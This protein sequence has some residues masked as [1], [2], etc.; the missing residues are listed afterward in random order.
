LQDGAIGEI[1]AT[2]VYWNGTTPWVRT[3]QELEAQAG[4][5]LSEM[6]YQLRNWYYFTWICGDHIVEQHIHNLDVGNWL[7]GAYDLHGERHPILVTGSARLAAYSR[8]GDSLQGRY[9]LH[10]LHPLTLSEL[11]GIG[12]PEDPEEIPRLSA[13]APAGAEEALEGLDRLGGFP[14]P[15]LSGS[16]RTAARWRLGYGARLVREDVRDL[17]DFRD[18]DRIES[19]FDALPATVGSLLSVNAL[20]EDLEVAYRTAATWLAGLER[21]YAVFRVPPFGPPKIRALRKAQKLYF[22]DWARI[23]GDAARAENLVLLHLLRLVHWLADLHGERA[24]LRF[25]RDTA[26][27]EVD[28]VV[29][30]GG[31]PW[32]AVEVKSGDAPLDRGLRY[33]LERV[34]VPW[35][36]QV[37]LRGRVDRVQAVGSRGRVRLVPAARFLASLP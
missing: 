21:L 22:W 27:H 16:A 36:F 11:C 2:R 33:L 25:F 3:R 34:P 5:K 6:E 28:A 1:T 23:P 18:L 26:G 30:R 14:E 24:E 13:A 32:M 29:V 15:L 9:F 31:K 19:L 20:R 7:K 35:A 17:E 37:A 4:R 8:G 12:V 10:R